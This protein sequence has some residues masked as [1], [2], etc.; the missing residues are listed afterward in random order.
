M[1]TR[2]VYLKRGPFDGACSVASHD[3]AI[4][5]GEVYVWD[6]SANRDS[7]VHAASAVRVLS[8]VQRREETQRV[9]NW[10][11]HPEIPLQADIPAWRV[12]AWMQ[13]IRLDAT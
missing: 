6:G 3:T 2:T 12:N 13:L 11:E 5:R 4:H 7:F 1:T 10:M 8:D 9:S